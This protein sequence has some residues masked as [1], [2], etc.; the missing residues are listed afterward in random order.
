MNTTNTFSSAG[1]RP[2]IWDA[3]HCYTLRIW[4]NS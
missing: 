2:G 1:N 4:G 3:R